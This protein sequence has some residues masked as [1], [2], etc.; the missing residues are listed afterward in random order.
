MTRFYLAALCCFTGDFLRCQDRRGL[1]V[2]I[3]VVRFGICRGG[4]AERKGCFREIFSSLGWTIIVKRLWE[5]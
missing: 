2:L 1:L 5:R 4:V 3:G